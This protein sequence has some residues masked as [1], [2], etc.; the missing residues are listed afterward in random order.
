MSL[1]ET[2]TGRATASSVIATG[3]DLVALLRDLALF[4]LAVLLIAFPATFNNVLTD[5][6]FEEGSLA[7]FKWRSK[8]LDADAALKEARATI[9]NLEN[10]LVETSKTLN[11]AQNRLNDPAL[12][13]LF[14]KLQE[15]NKSATEAS[16]KV[17]A[18][19]TNAIAS[20]APLVA[21]AQAAEDTPRTWGVVYSGDATLDKAK[22]EIEQVAKKYD[23]PNPVIYLRQGSYRSVSV[24]ENRSQADEVLPN[25]RKRRA[26]AYIVD[27]SKWCPKWNDRGDYRECVSQ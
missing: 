27:M 8:L 5:A 14:S 16:A 20:N 11:E 13:S 3:K 15:E 10:R 24:T 19:V 21:K 22:Y 26:D 18:S 17:Q 2:A 1:K 23:I 7:G 9:T 12:K 4:L 6:G 25:A